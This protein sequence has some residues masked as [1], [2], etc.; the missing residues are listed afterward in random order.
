MRHVPAPLLAAVAL[1]AAGLAACGQP[2][3]SARVEVPEIRVLQAP[4]NFPRIP[5]LDPNNPNPNPESACAIV[6]LPDCTGRTI[7]MDVGDALDQK[8]VSTELRLTGL[9]LHLTGGDA[10]GLSYAEVALMDPDT[11]VTTMIARYLRTSTDAPT[12]DVVTETSGAELS[13]FLKSGKLEAR[14]EVAID[15]VYL[16]TGFTAAV[17]ATFSAKVTVNYREL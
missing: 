15:P 3:L 16:P 14:V 8:G 11:G 5:P 6:Q 4:E 7:S 12:T 1:A 10:R 13:H 17:E 2:F 9:A